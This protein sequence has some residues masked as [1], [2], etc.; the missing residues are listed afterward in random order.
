MKWSSHRI[1]FR[2]NMFGDK[3]MQGLMLQSQ[4]SFERKVLGGD[5]V[6]GGWVCGWDFTDRNTAKV[7]QQLYFCQ[8]GV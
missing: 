3:T 2:Q 1:E 4:V 8:K 7:L 5:E 6:Q